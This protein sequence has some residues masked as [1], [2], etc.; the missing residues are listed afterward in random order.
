MGCGCR[1][2]PLQRVDARIAT[3]GWTYLANS[4]LGLVDSFIHEKLNVYPTSM[5]N[6]IELYSQAKSA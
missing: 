3:R 1:K 6:R 5:S 4:E 2:S